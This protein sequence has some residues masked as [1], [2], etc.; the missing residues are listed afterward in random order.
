M[1]DIINDISELLE[2]GELKGLSVPW[3]ELAFEGFQAAREGRWSRRQRHRINNDYDTYICDGQA[4]RL[5]VMKNVAQKSAEAPAESGH[6]DMVPPQPR[7]L[8]PQMGAAALSLPSALHEGQP[9]RWIQISLTRCLI[10]DSLEALDVTFGG[11]LIP[12][13]GHSPH[14]SA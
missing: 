2:G 14:H 9:M 5:I 7:S 6:L 10:G 11:A 1:L 3:R 4:D 13:S 12:S 8:F